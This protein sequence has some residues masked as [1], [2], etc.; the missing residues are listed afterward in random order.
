MLKQ[1]VVNQYEGRALDAASVMPDISAKNILMGFW[2]NWKSE[3]GQG[4]QQGL[5][6][7]MAL[8]D[9]PENYNVIAVAFMKGSGIPTFKPYAYSDL[10]FRQQVGVLNA[11]GRAVL[12]SLGGADAHIELYAGQEEALA[13]EI[14]RLVETY[15]FDGLDIDLEQLAITHADNRTV[16]PA[17]LRRVREYYKKEGRYFIISMAPE[18]P[19]LRTD[20]IY[21]DYIKAL[22]DLYDFIAPQYYNQ[23]GDG[24]WVDELNL[25]VTQNSDAH[26]KEFLYYL[27]DSLIHGTR[28]FTT[29][30]ADRL[31]I[32]LPSNN[33]AAATG[34][35][36]NPR[37]VIDAL[38]DLEKA[39]NPVRGLMTWSVNWD[40]GR[41][42]HGKPYNWEFLNRYGYLTGGETPVPEGP[43]VPTG[44]NSIS[45]T[46]SSI[47][48]GW[49]LASGT[50]PIQS[51]QVYRNGM[52]IGVTT[53]PPFSDS[54]LRPD[55]DYHYQVSAKDRH[56][57][58]SGLSK[59]LTVRTLSA[60]G[61]APEW[62]AGSLYKDDDLVTYRGVTYICLMVHTST[63][64]WAPDKAMSLWQRA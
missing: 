30:A 21:L 23:G 8:T 34:Y 59:T 15:G 11:Q 18:F 31:V 49:Q 17:A 19:H 53:T 33:D 27:T 5:F 56:G 26:K 1:T 32:G 37:S 36:V 9:I 51:Y 39:G 29:I 38:S 42:K 62:V 41:D 40:N 43:S 13:Y 46:S 50:H 45:Q 16:I 35:V 20:G 4:Y 7:E 25:W 12:I 10:E 61:T 14:I 60:G 58:N 44:L 3:G 63:S 64:W 28:G 22:D 47:L 2:H 6:A 48:L 55:T 24:I 57:N 54:G 52:S